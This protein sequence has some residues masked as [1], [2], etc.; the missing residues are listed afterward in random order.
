MYTIRS[1]KGLEILD[2]RGY[3]TIEVDLFLHSGAWGRASVPSGA[4]TGSHEALELRDGDPG[5]YAG[6]GVLKALNHIEHELLPQ[7]E[8]KTFEDQKAW[9]TWL[10]EQDGTA[11]KSHLG[12]NT[13][14]ALS[15][16]FARAIA[17]SQNLPLYESL[18]QQ[19]PL[20]LP[21]PMM[22]L[23]NGGVHADN[24]LDIQEF[25]VIPVG[26][27]SFSEA[28]HMGAQIFHNLK[29][30]LKARGFST[31]VG[32]EGGFAPDIKSTQQAFELLLEG[33]EKAGFKSGRDVYLGLDLAS[34]ELYRGGRYYLDSEHADYTRETFIDL[35][36]SWVTQYPILSLEDP[37]AEDDWEGWEHLTARLGNRVQLVGDDLFVTHPERL[38]RGAIKHVA[39][40]ILI[41]PNQIGTLTETLTTLSIAQAHAYNTI[42]SHR[43][44]ETEDTFIADLAVAAGAAQIKTGS[45]CRSERTAKY[46]QLLRIERADPKIPFAG[47]RPFARWII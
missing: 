43:S 16:A 15:L 18:K 33:I 21:V 13:T 35:L 20:C 45:L 17:A 12:A 41:K 9:D 5:R 25:M 32:D 26:A 30:L 11:N 14:L 38:M 10:I 47:K 34:S 31:A 1:I 36:A 7:L 8:S 40:A 29:D 37:L 4:S 2:S 44:G 3:P 23:I 42:L 6:K 24:A 19:K 39:N 27:S 46:N 28:L 22:N